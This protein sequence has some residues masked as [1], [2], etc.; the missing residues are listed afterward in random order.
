[1]W[2][3]VIARSEATRQSKNIIPAKAGI[4]FPFDWNCGFGYYFA[5]EDE[6]SNTKMVVL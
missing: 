6:P 3:R 5:G 1:M 4:H 2:F